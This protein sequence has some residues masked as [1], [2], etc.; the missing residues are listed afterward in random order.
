MENAG[1]RKTDVPFSMAL[2]DKFA[3]IS[4]GQ[5]MSPFYRKALLFK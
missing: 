3:R 1:L 5:D 2:K 4:K